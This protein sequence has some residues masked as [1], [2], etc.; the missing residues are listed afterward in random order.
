M[1]VFLIFF[2]A[3]A[4][5]LWLSIF[6]YALLLVVSACVLL[7]TPYWHWP[8]LTFVAFAAPACAALFA[9]KT[10]AVEGRG[11]WSLNLAAIRLLVL[12]AVSMLTLGPLSAGGALGG[13][14]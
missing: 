11:W 6:G 7:W 2:L 3:V 5:V 12:T 14:T 13:K 10:L 4:T 1:T 8:L 9:S